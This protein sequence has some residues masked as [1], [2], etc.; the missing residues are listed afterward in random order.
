MLFFG[1]FFA[2]HSEYAVTICGN[3]NVVADKVIFPLEARAGPRVVGERLAAVSGAGQCNRG[4]LVLQIA[5][6]IVKDDVGSAADRINRQPLHELISTIVQRI[7]IHPH[8]SAPALARVR[9][10]GRKHVD[11][12][13]MVVAP[14]QVE[15]SAAGIHADLRKTI[16]ALNA[17]DGKI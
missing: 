1:R 16:A 12:A 14:D 8:G 2:P 9:R 7:R 3:A 13:V 6:T 10:C 4:S 17:R 11:V 5:A 15:Q